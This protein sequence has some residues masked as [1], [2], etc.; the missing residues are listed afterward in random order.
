MKLD[1]W[2]VEELAAT[3][4][5]VEETDYSETLDEALYDKFDVS[6]EQ[7]HKIVEALVDYTIPAKSA[8]TDATYK[9]F[10]KDGAFIVKGEVE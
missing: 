8:L 5:G 9:G 2:D 1:H 4:L 10:I 7:F 3:I 6:F